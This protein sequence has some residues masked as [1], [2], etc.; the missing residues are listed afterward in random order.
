MFWSPA[1]KFNPARSVWN[2]HKKHGPSL[3]GFLSGLVSPD[4][5]RRQLVQIQTQEPIENNTQHWYSILPVNGACLGVETAH[6]QPSTLMVLHSNLSKLLCWPANMPKKEWLLY[7]T[8]KLFTEKN[9]FR[10]NP[11]GIVNILNSSSF[12]LIFLLSNSNSMM[13][14]YN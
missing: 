12:N 6:C 10:Y 7:S 1:N 8:H 2:T 11:F 5:C 13:L 4:W 9:I 14:L 3:K